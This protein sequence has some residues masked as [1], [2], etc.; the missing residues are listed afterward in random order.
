[1]RSALVSHVVADE[2]LAERTCA[3]CTGRAIRGGWQGI[4][5]D[6]VTSLGQTEACADCSPTPRFRCAFCGHVVPLSVPAVTGHLS[7]H[8]VR[9]DDD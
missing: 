3:E 9:P 1:M 6:G 5:P 4:G 2:T 8:D 7:R